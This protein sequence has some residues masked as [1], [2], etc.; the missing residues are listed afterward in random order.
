M[1]AFKEHEEVRD[2]RVKQM[3]ESCHA[4]FSDLWSHGKLEVADELIDDECVHK[5]MIWG[6]HLTVGPHALQKLVKAT[7][8]AYPDFW[9][10][11]DQVAVCDTTSVFVQ[12]E[13]QAT[14]LGSFHEHKPS[15]HQ[16]TLSGVTLF[17]FNKDRS[18]MV[19]VVVYRQALSEEEHEQHEVALEDDLHTLHLARL[20]FDEKT[21]KKQEH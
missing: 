5:N 7:R 12:W 13:G 4:Y 2:W 17:K 19:E 9:I 15:Y 3:V 6:E 8:Q 10:K 11:I 20:H 18:K 16:S 14:N 1:A 21:A